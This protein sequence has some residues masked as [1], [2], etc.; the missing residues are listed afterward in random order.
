MKIHVITGEDFPSVGR[1]PES[2]RIFV[3]FTNIA[4]S[5]SVSEAETLAE[6]L[7]NAV[8]DDFDGG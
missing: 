1:G 8:R 2:D 7:M 6:W 3:T 5:M 4:W